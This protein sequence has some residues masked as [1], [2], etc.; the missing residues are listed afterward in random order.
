MRHVYPLQLLNALIP[1]IIGFGFPLQRVRQMSLGEVSGWPRASLCDSG[2]LGKDFIFLAQNF[3]AYFL[4]LASVL[5]VVRK[6]LAYPYGKL[7]P[8]KFNQCLRLKFGFG[9]YRRAFQCQK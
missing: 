3:L 6:A 4:E 7:L 1:E 9:P 2:A 8:T 5:K